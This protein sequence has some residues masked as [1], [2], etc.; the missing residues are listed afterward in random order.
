MKHQS[1]EMKYDPE[2]ACWVVI[3]DGKEY[4]I[5]CGEYF[6]LSFAKKNVSCRLERDLIGTS[7]YMEFVSYYIPK[8]FI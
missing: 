6:D 3:L 2:M 1:S 4:I 5:H 7:L 8:R